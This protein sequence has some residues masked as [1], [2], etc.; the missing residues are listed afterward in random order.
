MEAEFNHGP[1]IMI[2]SFTSQVHLSG[3]RHVTSRSLQSQAGL[4]STEAAV[5]RIPVVHTK[6]IP[7]CE[8]VNRNY[9]VTRGMSIP[10]VRHQKRRQILAGL[11]LLKQPDPDLSICCTVNLC[12]VIPDAAHKSIYFF[13]AY[14]LGEEE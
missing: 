11:Q 9:F 7:G 1:D 14:T 10:K 8:T 12:T 6:P 13:K 4:T 3:Q 2:G 5:S